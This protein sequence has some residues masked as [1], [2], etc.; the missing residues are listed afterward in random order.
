MHNRQNDADPAEFERPP[1]DEDFPY[2]HDV[3][4]LWAPEDRDSRPRTHYHDAVEIGLCREGA[5]VFTVGRKVMTFKPGDMVVI[6]ALDP[7]HANSLKGRRSTWDFFFV[8]PLRLLGAFCEDTGNLAPQ[9]FSAD[10]FI[11]VL[12]GEDHPSLAILLGQLAEVPPPRDKAGRDCVRGL[13]LAFFARLGAIAR[14]PGAAPSAA[15]PP[16]VQDAGRFAR[17]APALQFIQRHHDR[18]VAVAELAGRCH[19]CVSGFRR[20]F[21]EVMGQAPHDY[22]TGYRLSMATADLLAGGKGIDQVARD[23]GYPQ[24]SS[25]FR[26]FRKRHGM[27]PAQWARERRSATPLTGWRSRGRDG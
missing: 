9:A 19:M 26:E 20:H 4:R 11:N 2:R 3:H 23:H 6:H 27:G 21:Q 12:L 13:L 5:G 10:A 7:H 8:N 1:L 22:L 15:T 24:R 18:K 16:P 14:E 17:I 25:F